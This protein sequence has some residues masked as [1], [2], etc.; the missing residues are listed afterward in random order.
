M[1]KAS[2]RFRGLKH[3]A[4]LYLAETTIGNDAITIMA[5]FPNLKKLRIAKNQID[6]EGMAALPKL[7]KL[8]E[9][10]LSECA[11]IADGD[12]APWVR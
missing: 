3:L 11:Q 1:T 9:L 12:M 5:G 8:E 4:E 2:T 7:T 10:D 6:G